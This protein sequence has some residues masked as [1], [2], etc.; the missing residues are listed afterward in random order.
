VPIRQQC[1]ALYAIALLVPLQLL[2]AD[3]ADAQPGEPVPGSPASPLYIH[4]EGGGSGSPVWLT[5]LIAGLSALGGA[6]L[7]HWSG[8]RR[9][10]SERSGDR[11]L[12]QL[13]ALV[14]A[15]EDLDAAYVAVGDTDAPAPGSETALVVAERK[16]RRKVELVAESDIRVLAGDW[17]RMQSRYAVS[18]GE[19]AES[20]NAPTRLQ[21]QTAQTNLFRR[22]RE[23]RESCR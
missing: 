3:I 19:D 22:V 10:R 21:V 5:G 1:R 23:E 4:V 6:Y 7:N 11:T 20:A 18:A 13:E 2:S 8:E 9:S 12:E 14:S 16:F 15:V 17:A